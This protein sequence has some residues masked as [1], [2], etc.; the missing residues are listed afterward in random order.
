MHRKSSQGTHAQH[1]QH[2]QLLEQVM[3]TPESSEPLQVKEEEEDEEEQVNH[4]D[5]AESQS[6]QCGK[7]AGPDFERQ[8]DEAC[9][10]TPERV[11]E[12]LS[13]IERRVKEVVSHMEGCLEG[14]GPRLEGCIGQVGRLELQRDAL[15]AQLLQLELPMAQAVQTLRAELGVAR[16]RL[17]RAELGKRSLQEQVR[18]VKRRL[19]LVARDC[20]QSQVTLATRQHEVAQFAIT[21]EELTAQIQGLAE[22]AS[23][24]QEDQQEQLR[25][26]QE[27]V[28][29]AG[30]RRRPCSDLTYNR[31][32][33]MEI[34]EYLKGGVLALERRYEPRLLALLR[35]RQWGEEAL[36]R[37][38]EEALDLRAHIG[39]LSEEL[40][41]LELQRV[42][43]EERVAL[44]ERERDENVAQYR[45]TLEVLEQGLRDLRTEVQV[46]K[47]TNEE[48]ENLKTSLTKELDVHR[49]FV[50]AYG[51]LRIPTRERSEIG[52]CET[53]R[54]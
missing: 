51:T 54:R 11:S 9:P 36:R 16:D 25:A 8:I 44:M 34:Q 28:R 5:S 43:L 52:S 7:G 14:A 1:Q 24:L 39:P 32:V 35:R 19:F 31:R 33:S 46:Q 53:L 48:M 2:L 13:Q 22:E 50:E 29:T 30:R 18:Q 10:L 37:H 38:R 49:R 3:E 23:Q 4:A 41:A 17:A 6:D 27:Q 26:A 20:I 12:V 21:Q 40:Q 45:E 15:V 47:K 42:C